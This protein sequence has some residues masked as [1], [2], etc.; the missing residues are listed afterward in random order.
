MNMKWVWLVAM[1]TVD[2]FLAALAAVL[3]VVW[4]NALAP[5]SAAGEQ[6]I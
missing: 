4:P 3:S 6:Q 5:R 2:G 1:V